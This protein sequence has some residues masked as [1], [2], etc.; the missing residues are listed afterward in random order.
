TIRH[1]FR[2]ALTE[3]YVKE[4]PA[5]NIESPKIRKN[6]PQFL[7][8]DEVEQLLQQP[9]VAD[10]AGLRDRAMIE[11]M[12]STGIRVS[13]LCGIRLADLRM[14][15]GCLRC[16]GKGDK[17]RLVP[18]GRRALEIVQKYLREGRPKLIG[19]RTSPFLFINRQSKPLSRNVFW[20]ITRDYGRK[21]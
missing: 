19:E 11:L 7:S 16:T 15:P 13:E 2:F 4:D 21:A 8:V 5:M 17:E 9:D 10:P 1:F 20:R 12:Y 6:L 18:V 3:D 14:D